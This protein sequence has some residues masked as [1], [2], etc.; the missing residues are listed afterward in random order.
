MPIDDVA[1]KM[2]EDPFTVEVIMRAAIKQRDLPP[3]FKPGTSLKT[4]TAPAPAPPSFAPRATTLV[5]PPRAERPQPPAPPP[6]PAGTGPQP[7]ISEGPEKS[8]APVP[9][10]EQLTAMREGMTRALE[11]KSRQNS[12]LETDL[13]TATG[14]LAQEQG[15]VRELQAEL[16]K[17][18]A[19]LERPDN[20]RILELKRRVNE[21]VASCESL[22]TE[23]LDSAIR[24]IDLEA[25]L[26]TLRAEHATN[27]AETEKLMLRLAKVSEELDEAKNKPVVKTND[28]VATILVAAGVNVKW[29]RIATETGLPLV[30]VQRIIDTYK[31]GRAALP[32]AKGA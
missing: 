25:A 1:T 6:V 21:L 22:T 7:V 24:S 2:Q 32:G 10:S 20:E 13:K 28:L 18:K 12:Q 9:P 23:A 4:S 14:A 27:R 15:R 19:E 26:E 30:T 11:E 16:A 3:D 29:E 5:A 31:A 17:L 8:F